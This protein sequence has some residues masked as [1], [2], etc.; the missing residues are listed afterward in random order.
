[1][2]FGGGGGGALQNHVHNNVPLQGGPLDFANDTI[3]SLNAGSTTFSDGAAL[4]ELVIGN[5]GDS[6]V[7][8]G[9]G[10]APEWVVPAGGGGTTFFAYQTANFSG[11]SSSYFAVYPSAN[12]NLWSYTESEFQIPCHT[13]LTFTR[14]VLN[15]RVNG[16]ASNQVTA[17]RDD[18]VNVAPITIPASSSGQFDSGVVSVNIASGS[19]IDWV[20]H[21]T[22][23]GNVD[24]YAVLGTVTT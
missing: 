4:Q 8:N 19:L 10:T 3:A 1:M 24:V 17:F 20:Y 11:T 16:K 14:F 12:D 6:L 2:S 22:V 5:A 23:A 9:A 21:A 13:A 7:V 15:I 18:G